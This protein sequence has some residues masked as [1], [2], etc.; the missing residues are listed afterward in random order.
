ME[1]AIRSGM[2]L[3]GFAALL[4]LAWVAAPALLLI[5]GGILLAV[6]FNA[7]T[8]ALGRIAGGGERVRLA[9]V[10][11]LLAAGL[12]AT[13]AWGGTALAFQFGQLSSAIEEQ[14]ATVT[15]W[16]SDLGIGMNRIGGLL[17]SS[18]AIFGG[19]TN[20]VF[21]LFGLVGNLVV[22]VFLGIFF[23]AEPRVYRG[24][25]VALLPKGKR[26]R[27]TQV[28]NEAAGTMRGWLF[29]Q[30]ISMIAIFFVSWA[31][32]TMLGMPYAFLLALQAGL[33]VFVPTLGPVIAGGVIVLS[34]LAQGPAMALWG[35]GV[36][37]L[38]QFLE[39]NLLTPLV[40]ER[41]V[42]LPPAF[43][44]GFQLVMG[45]LFGIPGVI[46]AVPIGA[47][48]KTL[49]YELYVNDVLGGIEQDAA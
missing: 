34:G 7:A 3:L 17:P 15:R 28:L 6:A 49:V 21:A 16:L 47:A 14:I 9:I 42:R 26:G 31:A 41:T 12:I 18:S 33:L 48:L 8:R 11:G 38:I 45:A 39:S 20:A 29:G 44:L 32:L 36:Y 1:Q 19:A 25:A 46:L 24:A 43:T 4:F 27:A 22:V 23:A 30:S 10:V 40:Q 37:V 13:L 2:V 5:F 35:L